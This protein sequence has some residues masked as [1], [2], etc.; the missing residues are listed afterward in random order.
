[1]RQA[2]GK[3]VAA[4]VVYEGL[5]SIEKSFDPAHLDGRLALAR[6]LADG[7]LDRAFGSDG[8]VS[9][10]FGG[11][12][13]AN[14]LA[15]QPD[16]EVVAGGLLG[17][18][19]EG[20]FALA[21]YGKHGAIDGGFGSRGRSVLH[22]GKSSLDDGAMGMVVRPDGSIVAAGSTS[23]GFRTGS[24][25]DSR[26]ALL[27]LRP[28]GR[29]NP[30]FGANGVVTTQFGANTA[31]KAY[32]LAEQVDGKLIV[33]GSALVRQKHG[34]SLEPFAIARYNP[35]GSLDGRFGRD[36]RVLTNFPFPGQASA[37][38]VAIQ[39]DGRIVVAGSVAGRFVLARY[40]P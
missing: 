8:Q 28:N 19:I 33:V 12:A 18:G 6:Y 16:G 32:G 34:P 4:G 26:F 7:S 1:V 24:R 31:V 37:N 13:I 30:S 9:T 23:L 20:R 36:G 14:S 11:L 3:L 27:G 5:G 29:L 22:I 15:I 35:S 2:D 10:A 25:V 17:N 38:A 40:L 21:R 39:P